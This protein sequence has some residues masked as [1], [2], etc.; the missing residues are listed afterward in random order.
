M[1]PFL[2]VVLI[3]AAAILSFLAARWI[4]YAYYRWRLHAER[5]R[6][7]RLHSIH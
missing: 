5:Q 2:S 1:N 7:E 4:G 6:L 3:P